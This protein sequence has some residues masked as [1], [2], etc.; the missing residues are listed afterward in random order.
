MFEINLIFPNFAISEVLL[1]VITLGVSGS[2]PDNLSGDFHAS[3]MVFFIKVASSLLWSFFQNSYASRT[4]PLNLVRSLMMS[5]DLDSNA[6][7]KCAAQR[8]INFMRSI[9]E[10]ELYPLSSKDFSIPFSTFSDTERSRTISLVL[11]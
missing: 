9:L 6:A 7:M 10:T 8:A 11:K 5:P 4:S 1:S 3:P 2:S